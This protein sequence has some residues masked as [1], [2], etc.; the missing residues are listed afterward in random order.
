[1]RARM[2]PEFRHLVDVMADIGWCTARPT[3]TG[4]PRAFFRFVNDQRW[5]VK[6]SPQN[7]WRIRRKLPDVLV[8]HYVYPRWQWFYNAPSFET[9][10]AAALWFDRVGLALIKIERQLK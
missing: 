8:G 3:D 7:T 5:E 9:P 6:R 10:A 2:R 1:M 4:L